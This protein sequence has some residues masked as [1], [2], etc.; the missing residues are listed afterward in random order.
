MG[1]IMRKVDT[2]DLLAEL[3]T[4]VDELLKLID[5]KLFDVTPDMVAVSR[6]RA[7]SKKV[8]DVWDADDE[9]TP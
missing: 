2:D 4:E 9:D 1:A 3:K 5:S 8:E 6:L 7:A